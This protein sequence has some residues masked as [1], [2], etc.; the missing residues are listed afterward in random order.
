M[1]RAHALLQ[2][3]ADGV[4]DRATGLVID[5]F[6]VAIDSWIHGTFFRQVPYSR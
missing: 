2:P 3:F 6:V 5:F 1:V 4:A